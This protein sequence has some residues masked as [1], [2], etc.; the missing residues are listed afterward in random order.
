MSKHT[1]MR[2]T[3]TKGSGAILVFRPE[4]LIAV[5][6]VPAKVSDPGGADYHLELAF[7]GGSEANIA[8]TIPEGWTLEGI[9][10]YWQRVIGGS[11]EHKAG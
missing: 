5:G 1:T 4:E 3:G 6:V 9:A 8:C 10:D 2:I 7:R 11:D